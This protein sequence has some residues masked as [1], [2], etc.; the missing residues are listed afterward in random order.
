M[1]VSGT[2]VYNE[3]VIVPIGFMSH[4][5]KRERKAREEDGDGILDGDLPKGADNADYI[6]TSPTGYGQQSRNYR[7]LRKS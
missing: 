4:N 3:I 2:L 5:T 7:Q 6:A 1:L